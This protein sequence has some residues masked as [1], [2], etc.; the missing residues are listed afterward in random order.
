SLYSNITLSDNVSVTF[1]GN[2]GGA[3][4]GSSYSTITLSD[5]VSVTFSG[6]NGGAIFGSSTIT[7]SDNVSVTF[8][9][10]NGGAIFGSSYSNITLSDNVS[11]TF[12]GNTAGYG[13]SAIHGDSHSTIRLIGNNS[14]VFHDNHAS[15]SFGGAILSDCGEIII[16]ENEILS[17]WRNTAGEAGG[18]IGG[19]YGACTEISNNSYVEFCENSAQYGAALYQRGTL[20][21]KYIKVIN[22]EDVRFERN[23][24]TRYGGAIFCGVGVQIILDGNRN[25]SFS[26]NTSARGGAVYGDV[27]DIVSFDGNGTVSFT[28]N[29]ASVSGGA[30]GGGFNSS[31]KLTNNDKLI[32]S[33]NT[34]YSGG[35]IHTEGNLNIRNNGEVLFKRNAE[36]SGDT[37]RLRSIYAGGSG[38]IISFSAADGKSI[39]F[40]DSIYIESGSTVN[41]NAD[42][43][44]AEG[45]VH[46]QTGDIIF[47]GATTEADL[48]AVKGSVG[49][50]EEILASRTSE[51]YTMTNLYG[52]SLRIE[53]GAI[54]MGNG[55]TVHEGAEA[56]LLLRDGTLSHSGYD[57]TICSGSSL[58]VLGEN[59]ITA[60]TLAIQDGGILQ[61]AL[62][63]AQVDNA[64]VLTT[65]GTLDMGAIALNLT[66]TE[67]LVSGD[68][69]LLTRTEGVNY[70]TSDWALNGATS[71]QLRWE[72][73]TLYY[74]CGFDWNHGVTDDDDINDLTEIL[75][76]LIINGGDITLD[77][78]VQAIQDAVDAGFGH[79][80]GH[81]V[82][83]RGGIH[84]TGAGDLDG[85][86]IFNGDLKDI[87]KLFIEK[88][89]TVIKIELGG[90]S[91]AENIVDVSDD[92]TL[93]VNELSGEGSMKKNG[94]GKMK[95]T[96]TNNQ[97]G[98]TLAVEEGDIIME[99]GS[100]T[101]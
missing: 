5:N 85:H 10:N 98:G 63:N 59:I 31:I 70:N 57:I 99:T 38:D 76:N 54:Y 20:T 11:V 72:N 17:F 2:N 87:R 53:D 73:G 12:S 81:I 40:R 90:S 26:D 52:G 22:N 46:K 88:D 58:S 44:N 96:G 60:S 91:E 36:I 67:Y 32:F 6:N 25:L 89:I 77:D 100:Q 68:Y 43:T 69:K 95:I 8:S 35:A 37:Y 66:G 41:F 71:E 42:Y 19:H 49:T 3:I 29:D 15:G 21:P 61:L 23:T 83:N 45:V 93:E 74:T 94:H 4:Y 101:D 64:A 16:S 7:L 39:K 65:T 34:A 62:D 82:I 86:I 1:S 47:T 92:Q 56:T 78:V 9:G 18:A 84:I 50:A 27:D 48:L 80:Q 24:T 14:L 97:V 75:G 33:D 51:V 13:G 55:I 28:G 30:I 79:G